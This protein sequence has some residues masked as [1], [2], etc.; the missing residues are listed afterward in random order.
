MLIDVQMN[1]GMHSKSWALD[2]LCFCIQQVSHIIVCH[3]FTLTTCALNNH[4]SAVLTATS[5]EGADVEGADFTDAY[6]G[7]FDI[8][9]L[10]K[11]PTLKV[12][13]SKS[14]NS[15]KLHECRLSIFFILYWNM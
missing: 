14:L 9:N 15:D 6:I 7:D 8:R 10:C 1:I 3:T 2:Y 11:N 4:N 5:F 13:R 12:S